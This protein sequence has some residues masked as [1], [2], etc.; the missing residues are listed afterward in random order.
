MVGKT[1]QEQTRQC[2]T[3]VE[4]ILEEAGSSLARAVSFTVVLATKMTS[5]P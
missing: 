5:Q 4:A 3:N 1:I 2:L